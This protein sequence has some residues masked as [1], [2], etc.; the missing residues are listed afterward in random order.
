MGEGGWDA[1]GW[2]L[3]VVTKCVK[4][5]RFEKKEQIKSVFGLNFANL[6]FTCPNLP[7]LFLPPNSVRHCSGQVLGE[8][9][10]GC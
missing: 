10:G 4:V 8:E 3:K 1:R 6:L 2:V 7:N 5:F 9:G